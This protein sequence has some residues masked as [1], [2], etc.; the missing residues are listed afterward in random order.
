MT[1]H[2]N[3]LPLFILAAKLVFG[4]VTQ[5]EMDGDFLYELEKAKRK[6]QRDNEI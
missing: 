1:L 6:A 4:F 5:E 3:E 2:K